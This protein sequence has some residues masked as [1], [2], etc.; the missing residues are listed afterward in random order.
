MDS[1]PRL[2]PGV[3]APADDAVRV[4]RLGLALDLEVAE[5]VE[6]ERLGEEPARRLV[7][8]TSPGS[9][10]VCM[11]AATFTASPSAVYS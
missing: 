3:A 11:R 8:S 4:D 9:A 2:R 5:V 10:A 1:R 6:L 7:M